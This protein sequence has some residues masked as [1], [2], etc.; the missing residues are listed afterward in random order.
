M[1]NHGKKKIALR[2]KEENK[3]VVPGTQEY[4]DW[5][6]SY[7]AAGDP[8]EGEAQRVIAE[9]DA[10][11]EKRQHIKEALSQ[12]YL[13]ENP[14]EFNKNKT[15]VSQKRSGE[16][17]VFLAALQHFLVE[18]PHPTPTQ[19][20]NFMKLQQA[21]FRTSRAHIDFKVRFPHLNIMTKEL[22]DL[23]LINKFEEA[24]DQVMPNP[25]IY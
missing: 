10:L 14:E 16:H 24:V 5:Y 9:Y 12:V 3:D 4:N 17:G 18:V 6:R 22:P 19:K 21:A 11:A 23:E 7:E 13:L 25:E 1:E 20:L 2:I 15:T 8:F